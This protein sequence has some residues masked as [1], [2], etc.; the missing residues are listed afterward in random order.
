MTYNCQFL[1]TAQYY[2]SAF[3]ICLSLPINVRNLSAY[4][5]D[6]IASYHQQNIIAYGR[7]LET[8]FMN[9]TKIIGD[10]CPP[11]GTKEV[12][13]KIQYLEPKSLAN[14]GIF[15]KS[16]RNQDNKGK[17]NIELQ[18]Y[19]Q[20]YRDSQC[21]IFFAKSM[22]YDFHL[23]LTYILLTYFYYYHKYI[24]KIN[25]TRDSRGPGTKTITLFI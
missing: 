18:V 22:Y 2:N 3:Q 14:W 21:R 24:E 11:W 9:N 20:G 13:V 6:K 23:R 4:K 15:I 19:I 17:S 10:K 12:A 5:F 1:E 8:L 16:K 7:I 25:I